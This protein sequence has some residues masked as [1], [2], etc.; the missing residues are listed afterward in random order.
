MQW[1][2]TLARWARPFA[3]AAA[4]AL[5]ATPALAA[6]G[7]PEDAV[8]ELGQPAPNFTLEDYNGNEVSLSDFAGKAVVIHW[9]SCNCPYDVA[10]QPYLN[11][12]AE[13]FADAEE[14]EM[15]VQFVGI[16]SNRTEDVEQIAE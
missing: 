9:Q 12:L 3:A 14:G 6:E 1:T 10:Y 5:A 13:R 11:E 2:Q 4:L 16:N 15:E 7:N 8:L